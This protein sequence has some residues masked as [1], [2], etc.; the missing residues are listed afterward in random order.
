MYI[1][2]MRLTLTP[3]ESVWQVGSDLK[4]R[5]Y[6]PNRTLNKELPYTKTHA[7]C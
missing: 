3:N 6:P 2:R 5:D 7:R 4:E 1:F